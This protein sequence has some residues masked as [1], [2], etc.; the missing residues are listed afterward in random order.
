MKNM[1]TDVINRCSSDEYLS[2]VHEVWVFTTHTHRQENY[3]PIPHINRKDTAPWLDGNTP[4]H[5]HLNPWLGDL[6][7]DKTISAIS[8]GSTSA[9]HGTHCLIL[10]T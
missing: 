5:C 4:A 2:Y 6:R 9:S 8:L 10:L 7:R 1:D 3:P